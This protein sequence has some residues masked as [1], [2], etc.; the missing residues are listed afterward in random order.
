MGPLK[1]RNDCIQV[2]G[3]DDQPLMDVIGLSTVHQ[4]MDRFG[5]WAASALRTLLVGLSLVD[6]R[7][8]CRRF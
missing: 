6:G 5:E 4:P 8:P 1:G 3:F 7:L 2:I